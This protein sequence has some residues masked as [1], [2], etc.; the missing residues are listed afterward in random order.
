M[1]SRHQ[2]QACPGCRYGGG[3]ASRKICRGRVRENQPES[4]EYGSSQ[5]C[6]KCDASRIVVRTFGSR[7]LLSFARRV[8]GV[9]PLR[10]IS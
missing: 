4:E 9:R 8:H 3:N 1:L 7:I 10:W 6:G 2:I 5:N